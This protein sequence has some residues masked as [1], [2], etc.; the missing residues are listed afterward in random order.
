MVNLVAVVILSLTVGAGAG[1]SSVP[2]ETVTTAAME[3]GRRQ[4]E[5]VTRDAR[6]PKFGGCWTEAL[7]ELENGCSRLTD[8]EQARLALLFA[9]CFLAKA[10]MAGHPCPRGKK[11]SDCVHN[12]GTNAFNAFTTFFTV[13]ES[14]RDTMKLID[15]AC[16]TTVLTA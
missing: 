6:S 7:T 11:V 16:V 10:G 4:L 14:Y 5:S 15:S 8:D 13:R 12:M 9:N 2:E 3:E 1:E